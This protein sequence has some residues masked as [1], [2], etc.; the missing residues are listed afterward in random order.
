MSIFRFET[1][2]VD[3]RINQGRQCSK[4][5]HGE[6]SEREDKYVEDEKIDVDLDMGDGSSEL[7]NVQEIREEDGKEEKLSLKQKW[8]DYLTT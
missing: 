3:T 5:S 1:S 4:P 2:V 8:W 6:E 7:D